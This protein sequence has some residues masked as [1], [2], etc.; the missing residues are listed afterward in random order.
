MAIRVYTLLFAPHLRNLSKGSTSAASLWRIGTHSFRATG[1]TEY[2]RNGGELEIA[3]QMAKGGP[4]G[5]RP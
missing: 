4:D 3:R 2:L 5:P 1:I